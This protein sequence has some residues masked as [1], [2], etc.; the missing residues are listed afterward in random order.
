[1][2]EVE[3]I[4]DMPE[5]YEGVTKECRGCG[6]HFPT[7]IAFQDGLCP[8]CIKIVDTAE[9][10]PPPIEE[11]PTFIAPP[12]LPQIEEDEPEDDDTDEQQPETSSFEM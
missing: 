12:P 1:M 10:I 2:T 8:D 4:V 6:V 3:N 7:A 9:E 11:E 5:S